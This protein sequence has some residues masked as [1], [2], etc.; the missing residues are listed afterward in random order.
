MRI[1]NLNILTV[2]N[3]LFYSRI[4][5]S[6]IFGGLILFI[7]NNGK[8]VENQILNAVLVFGLLLFCLLLG[9]IGCVLLR[10]YFTSKSKYPYI[11]N[12]ICNMLGFGRKRLQKENI[13]INLDDFI[14]DNN[15]SLILYYINNPQYPILDFHKNKIRYFTQEYDWENFRWRYKIKS[16]GRNSIQILEYEGINQNNEKIKDFI[17]FEKIDAEENEVLL[18]FIVHDL[19]FGK[20]SSIYY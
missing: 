7:T 6:L 19:L 17:D 9:Q 18:L 10:I 8:M 2:T 16:Q 20:S 11:L 14:K 1:S 12:I 3:I 4:V 15:L 5:I 13:N